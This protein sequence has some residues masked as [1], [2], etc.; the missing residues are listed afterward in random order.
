MKPEVLVAGLI[1]M[2]IFTALTAREGSPSRAILALIAP[3][4]GASV[5]V[6][7]VSGLPPQL[8]LL[9]VIGVVV[10]AFLASVVRGYVRAGREVAG[11]GRQ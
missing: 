6:F 11:P 10:V 3:M 2:A 1:V 7:L 4:A 5:G 9:T 8:A